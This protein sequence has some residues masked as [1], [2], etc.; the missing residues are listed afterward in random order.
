MSGKIS[1]SGGDERARIGVFYSYSPHFQQAV[2]A[3][4]K[5]FPDAELVALVPP[6]YP[7]AHIAPPTD[8]IL[9]IVPEP[10]SRIGLRAFVHVLRKIRNEHLSGLVVLF[11]TPRL[12]ILSWCSGAKGRYCYTLDGRWEVLYIHPVRG[13]LGGAIRQAAGRCRYFRIWC[14][15]YFTRVRPADLGPSGSEPPAGGAASGDDL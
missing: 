7:H 15:V 6:T 9:E 10:G 1:R 4:R 11:D 5:R 8:R 13:V 3:V 14:S 12:Q 2:Q